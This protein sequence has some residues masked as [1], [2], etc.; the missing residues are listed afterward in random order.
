MFSYALGAHL[1][2]RIGEK[3]AMLQ[4]LKAESAMARDRSR[5][6]SNFT[7][8]T[9][10]KRLLAPPADQLADLPKPSAPRYVLPM[11]LSWAIKQLDDQELN[12]LV[13]AALA[14]MQR[15]G[16]SPSQIRRHASRL[17]NAHH[18]R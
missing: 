10:V 16:S 18:V 15:R 12:R 6:P 11:N 9:A 14:E 2:E 13:A 3:I 8:T 5:E 17:R 1:H 7:P 4:S